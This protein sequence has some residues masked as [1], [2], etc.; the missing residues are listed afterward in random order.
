[1]PALDE[2]MMAQIDAAIDA[3][4]DMTPT[5]GEAITYNPA[6]VEAARTAVGALRQTLES[7]VL[8]LAQ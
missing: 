8:P 5:F 3:I 7:E 6:A 4:G 2:T 1:M